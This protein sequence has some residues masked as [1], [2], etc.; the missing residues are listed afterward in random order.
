MRDLRRIHAAL[1]FPEI[2]A[3]VFA[4]A[5]IASL[6]WGGPILSFLALSVAGATLSY[7]VRRRF[8]TATAILAILLSAAWLGGVAGLAQE[9]DWKGA[10]GALLMLIPVVLCWRAVPSAI[11]LRRAFGKRSGHS[12][13]WK[14]RIPRDARALKL[15]RPTAFC[16]LYFISGS[17][18]FLFGLLI[19]RGFGAGI[20][21]RPFS[22]RANVQYRR[23][24]Q[25]LSYRAQEIRAIDNRPAVL[26]LHS[27]MDDDLTLGRQYG[28][29][30]SIFQVSLTLEELAVER[31]WTLGPVIAIGKPKEAMSPLGATREYIEGGLWQPHVSE[32]ARAKRRGGV[33]SWGDGRPVVGVSSCLGK[34]PAAYYRCSTR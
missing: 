19:G 14:W 6:L 33:C 21:F 22:R 7:L 29:F 20:A 27:F 13:K 28:M 4:L 1:F 10:L 17:V 34:A 11:R 23:V 24:L 25:I 31:I 12:S 9:R 18:A 3:L 32:F 26:F 2:L 15:I 30:R 8:V 5:V 16:V